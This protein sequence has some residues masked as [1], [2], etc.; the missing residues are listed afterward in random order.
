M[1][2]I[3]LLEML[4]SEYLTLHKKLFP[5]SLKIKHHNL[6]HYPRIMRKYGPLKCMTCMRFEGKHKKI[7]ENSKICTTR[8]NSSFTLALRHQLQLCYRFL[9]NEG[10]ANHMLLGTVISKLH[11]ISTYECFRK[12]LPCDTFQNYDCV[13]WIIINGIKYNINAVLCINNNEINPVYGKVKHVIISP[14]IRDV[15]FLY[16]KMITVCHCHHLSAFE[17]KET[18]EWGFISHKD[19]PDCYA[20]Y[21]HIMTDKKSYVPT[22]F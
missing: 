6:L 3:D 14:S 17:V 18:Q 5:N 21:I 15:F 9:C 22:N 7:K 12:L 19:L 10:F 2:T 1:Q 20:Y 11:L 8:I 13:N 16:T 4:I